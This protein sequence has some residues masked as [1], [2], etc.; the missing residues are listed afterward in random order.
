[1]RTCAVGELFG[2]P[3]IDEQRFQVSER[4]GFDCIA[5]K[6]WDRPDDVGRAP[7]TMRCQELGRHLIKRLGFN[8]DSGTWMGGFIVLDDLRERDLTWRLAC[9]IE[10]RPH[11]DCSVLRRRGQRRE[12]G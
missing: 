5:K 11:P 7:G 6:V 10:E 8:C 12:N 3:L 2:R 4:T 9:W 1:M